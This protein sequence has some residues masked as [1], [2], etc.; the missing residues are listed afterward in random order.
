MK[1]TECI[2]YLKTG[3]KAYLIK[4]IGKEIY[5]VE[6]IFTVEAYD[7]GEVDFM[8]DQ[9]IVDTVYKNPPIE[10]VNEECQKILID[11]NK[12]TKNLRDLTD[13]KI[14][15]EAEINKIKHKKTVMND[16][17]Y[18]RSKLRDAKSI[19]MFGKDNIMP[20]IL[21]EKEKKYLK[22]SI[23]LSAYSGEERAWTYS[24]YGDSW[25]NSNFLDPDWGF[26][27]DLSEKQIVELTKKRIET[28]SNEY[29]RDWTIKATA[30]KYLTPGLK[31]RKDEIL[32]KRKQEEIKK[33]QNTIYEAKN[34]MD[35]LTGKKSE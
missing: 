25:S 6:P 33:T 12:R 30:D 5:L 8:G 22:I 35:I 18:D 27:Y 34:K 17:I 3:Q 24:W 23:E 32:K 26:Y 21:D 1:N 14:I 10:K 31:N 28:K 7:G 13:E 16:L 9:K 20:H 19:I 11:I 29:F 2:V 15:L 4:R